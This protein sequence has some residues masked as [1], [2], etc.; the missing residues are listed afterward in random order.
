[1][2]NELHGLR[3][4]VKDIR[5]GLERIADED[6]DDPRKFQHLTCMNRNIMV[7]RPVFIEAMKAFADSIDVEIQRLVTE[8]GVIGI[9]PD[10]GESDD[11]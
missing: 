10:V 5:E 1:M 9:E 7:P 2:A 11:D 8:F 4:S 3:K 6:E